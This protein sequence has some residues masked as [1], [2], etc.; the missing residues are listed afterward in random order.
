MVAAAE[1]VGDAHGGDVH[2]ALLQHLG[3][4]QIGFLV[5]AEIETSS[6]CASSQS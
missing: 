4:G 1:F 2:L 3:L 6:P 5:R